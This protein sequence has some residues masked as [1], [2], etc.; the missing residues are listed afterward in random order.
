[1]AASTGYGPTTWN[2][3]VLPLRAVYDGDIVIAVDIY[4]KDVPA[5]VRD[6]LK[7]KRVTVRRL[8]TGSPIGVKGNRYMTYADTS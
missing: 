1:M 4:E 5:Q 8:L 7:Q 3:F 2:N 6:M